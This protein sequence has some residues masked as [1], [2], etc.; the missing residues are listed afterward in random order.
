MGSRHQWFPAANVTCRWQNLKKMDALFGSINE[1]PQSICLSEVVS[2]EFPVMPLLLL[3][4][5]LRS[6]YWNTFSSNSSTKYKKKQSIGKQSW[7]PF[8]NSQV[9]SHFDQLIFFAGEIATRRFL[10]THSAC[11]TFSW[12][13]HS[14]PLSCPTI[15]WQDCNAPLNAD[16]GKV[17]FANWKWKY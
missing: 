1:V 8:T 3:V 9:F 11:I 6:C 2:K 13:V 10:W 14:K 12:P 5:N 15:K 4:F 17:N 7:K 16:R